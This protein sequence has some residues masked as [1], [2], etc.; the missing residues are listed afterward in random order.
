MMH[1][2]IK[3]RFEVFSC[4]KNGDTRQ[5][6]GPLLHHEGARRFAESCIKDTMWDVVIL[7]GVLEKKVE[8]FKGK[9]NRYTTKMLNRRF[10]GWELGEVVDVRI[11]QCWVG[12]P[13]TVIQD[14]TEESLD[15]PYVGTVV[16]DGLEHAV[17]LLGGSEDDLDGMKLSLPAE[18]FTDPQEEHL[19]QWTDLSQVGS[20]VCVINQLVIPW[21][22]GKEAPHILFGMENH[23]FMDQLH[24]L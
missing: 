21:V 15:A 5:G 22:G 23:V 19:V 6:S 2:N 17:F 9:L 16:A 20:K 14:E 12:Y 11:V 8:I 10:A 13:F 3:E 18:R 4:D 7:I 1:V 24:G